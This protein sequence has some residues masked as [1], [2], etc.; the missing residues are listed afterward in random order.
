MTA[1]CTGRPGSDDAGPAA[2]LPAAAGRVACTLAPVNA[3]FNWW[4]LIVGLVIGAGSSGSS[5]PTRG[6]GKRRPGARARAARRAGSPT[7]WPT[8]AEPLDDDEVLEVL[9][10]H[11][12]LPRGGAAGRAVDDDAR[13]SRDRRRSPER[14]R[15]HPIGRTRSDARWRT[16]SRG[17]LAADDPERRGPGAEPQPVA[18]EDGLARHV[19][20]RRGRRARRRTGRPRAETGDLRHLADPVGEVAAEEHLADRPPARR[21]PRPSSGTRDR[22]AAAPGPRRRRRARSRSARRRACPVAAASGSCR[23]ARRAGRPAGRRSGASSGRRRRAPRSPRPGVRTARR[24]WPFT[25]S[26]VPAT[27]TISAAARPASEPSD[28]P[29]ARCG[30][31]VRRPR[32]RRR[33]HRRRGGRRPL[34]RRRTESSAASRPPRAAGRRPRRRPASAPGARAAATVRTAS[35]DDGRRRGAGARAPRRTPGSR[36]GGRRAPPPPACRPPSSRS[37]P[38]GS[39]AAISRSSRASACSIVSRHRSR[40][41]RR[42]AP[43]P[44]PVPRPGRAPRPGPR[45]AAAGPAASASSPFR[46][47]SRAARRSPI[48]SAPRCRPGRWP[49]A[50]APAARP[51]RPRITSRSSAAASSPSGPGPRSAPPRTRAR[52]DE[53]LEGRRVA[54]RRSPPADESGTRFGRR[55]AARSRSTVRLRAIVWSHAASEPSR[56]VEQLRPVPEREE[57]LL[58]YLFGDL[59]I[60]CQPARRREDRVDVPVVQSG[61]RV[62]RTRRDLADEGRFVARA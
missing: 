61:Q 9:R 19:R 29:T 6:G 2:G 32:G 27:A 11:A 52:R 17:V 23:R 47:A 51:A 48:A 45:A 39:T 4:L 40:F 38:S 35:P 50:R 43:R 53:P 15:S 41:V 26:P 55:P 33:P 54:A 12:R 56:R 18:D 7:R 58:H 46:A 31:A 20:R 44:A 16:R 10:L 1:E 37:K 8:P 59:P 14:L 60:R 25:M 49:S 3:E 13:A 22:R 30:R 28:G 24:G 42:P 36:R 21:R 62:L 57:R 34:R 5:S